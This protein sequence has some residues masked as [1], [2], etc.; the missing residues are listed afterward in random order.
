M[1]KKN[2]STLKEENLVL[3]MSIEEAL[4]IVKPL[5]NPIFKGEK[6]FD[7]I[8]TLTALAE[9]Y[10][11]QDLINREDIKEK[12]HCANFREEYCKSTTPCREC[13]DYGLMA[14][15]IEKIP[16]AQPPRR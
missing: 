11:S 10:N 12:C 4:E 3:P 7:A 16:K 9:W 13:S 8:N 14:D 2:N 15:E 6:L 1:T 5:Q